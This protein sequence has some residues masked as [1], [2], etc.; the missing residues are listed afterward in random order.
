[1]LFGF[2][3]RSACMRKSRSMRRASL[4]LCRVEGF[5]RAAKTHGAHSPAPAPGISLMPP[6]R[7]TRLRN[8][9]ADPPS[10][11]ERSGK[12][13][14]M[15]WKPE[16][17]ELARRGELARRMGGEERLARARAAGRLDVRERIDR[18]LDPG[19]F[20]ETGLLAGR[21]A[22]DAQGQLEALTPSNFVCG[23]GRIE[24]RPVVVGADDFTVR[25]GASD[26]ADRQQ[27]GMDGEG[28]A[29]AAAAA[30]QTG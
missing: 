29:R 6:F 16:L 13:P 25:G 15:S 30:R 5:E 1:M 28:G 23:R 21:A 14:A 26:G 4:P 27:D 7:T 20:H 19:S 11:A 10:A 17:E 9:S 18:L 24:G 8:L 12:M 3:V 2:G 22:Y